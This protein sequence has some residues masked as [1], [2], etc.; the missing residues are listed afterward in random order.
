MV[1]AAVIALAAVLMPVAAEACVIQMQTCDTAEGY[2]TLYDHE[3]SAVLFYDTVLD[4]M[5]LHQRMVL[6]ECTS[7]QAVM[8]ELPENSSEAQWAA[9]TYMAEVLRGDAPR[10]I[11]QISRHLRGLGVDVVRGALAPGHCGCD[12]PA[13]PMPDNYCPDF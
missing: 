3:G 6:A 4:G 10:T 9:E 1:R 12:L 8:L 2:A 11:V 5:D 13:M 7:R